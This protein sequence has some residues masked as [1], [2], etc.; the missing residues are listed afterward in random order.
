MSKNGSWGGWINTAGTGIDT[1][2]VTQT[3]LSGASYDTGTA[4]QKAMD[5]TGGSFKSSRSAMDAVSYSQVSKSI[6]VVSET[7]KSVKALDYAGNV[8]IGVQAAHA[9]YES[10]QRNQ[11]LLKSSDPGDRANYT[12]RVTFSA[13]KSV[14]S[15]LV[16]GLAAKGGMKVGAVAGAKI[17]AAVG[18]CFG[19]IGAP[20]GAAVGAVVGGLVGYFAAKKLTETAIDKGLE[21]LGINEKTAGALTEKAYKTMKKAR[22]S[23][24]DGARSLASKAK[25]VFDGISQS[26]TGG[27][28]G[29]YCIPC[30]VQ[31]IKSA[32][33][34]AAFGDRPTGPFSDENLDKLV[35]EDIQGAGSPALKEAMHKLAT[36]PSPEEL[37]ALLK[38]V[39]KE[40]GLPPGEGARQYAKYL[41]FKKAQQ[42]AVKGGKEEVPP[43]AEKHA[44]HMG[45]VA[46]LRFG[47]VV[48]AQ[49]GVDPVFG[50]LLS[51][52]GGIVGPGN[53]QVPLISTNPDDPVVIHGAV[54]DAAGYLYNYHDMGPG[55]NY[56]GSKLEPLDTSS[57]LCGQVSGISYWTLKRR[58]APPSRGSTDTSG[59]PV[60]D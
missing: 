48:G 37:P 52:T 15:E 29:Y 6:D 19:G 16:S 39:E 41:E 40:R 1:A 42:Q 36:G 13:A 45:S 30:K 57:P 55:Y 27:P 26:F 17:G 14:G 44:D 23:I 5:A 8:M 38:T 9:A 53:S 34:R 18:V 24:A 21:A 49:L 3:F 31:E 32:V 10:H 22:D 54:H 28:K 47:K 11:A 51:P 2:G 60:D 58:G 7:S 43:L 50:A 33:T 35:N 59:V 56:L 4:V 20:V 46:Q 12:G 25:G